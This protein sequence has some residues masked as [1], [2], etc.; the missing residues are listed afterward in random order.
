MQVLLRGCA[1]EEHSAVHPVSS[2]GVVIFGKCHHRQL[3]KLDPE[4]NGS[5]EIPLSVAST[6]DTPHGEIECWH[7]SRIEVSLLMSIPMRRGALLILMRCGILLL[8]Q[9]LTCSFL[10]AQATVSQHFATLE[11]SVLKVGSAQ[12]IRRADVELRAVTVQASSGG[13]T[14]TGDDTVL[15]VYRTTSDEAGGFV[16]EGVAPGTYLLSAQR[17]G[18]IPGVYGARAY[19]V[20][21]VQITVR[22]GD[23][24]RQLPVFLTPQAEIS[25]RVV[26]EDGEP[27]A[28]AFLAA[29][30]SGDSMPPRRPT[31]PSRPHAT[32]TTNDRGEYRLHGIPPGK[33]VLQVIPSLQ[34]RSVVVERDGRRLG[35]VPVYA[36]DAASID[37]AQVVQLAAGDEIRDVHVVLRKTD[38]CRI[39]GQVFDKA[40]R[41]LREYSIQL[42]SSET[43]SPFPLATKGGR[44]SSGH[45]VLDGIPSGSYWLLVRAELRGQEVGFLNQL[46]VNGGN[47][48]DTLRIVVGPLVVL[49]G[50]VSVD[51]HS[52]PPP[53]L[54]VTLLSD[55]PV[56]PFVGYS[57]ESG[58]FSVGGVFPGAYRVS[59][60]GLQGHFLED[61]HLGENSILGR[62]VQ[63]ADSTAEV[64]VRLSSGGGHLSG[65]VMRDRTPGVGSVCLIPTSEEMR[66][67]PLLQ[68]S[69][70]DQHGRFELN[71]IRP[72]TY[73]LF[74]TSTTRCD[75]YFPDDFLRGKTV[76]RVEVSNGIRGQVDLA[77]EE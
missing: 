30:A 28:G 31:R 55:L 6:R 25:G 58:A 12:P 56:R 18:F 36:P 26:D 13:T 40:G 66:F 48:L 29:F 23:E 73:Y 37:R 10:N 20:L 34:M 44:I 33:F 1:P 2:P 76:R 38:I 15:G 32:A 68:Q 39:S 72:G 54:A 71:H 22:P 69:L 47:S 49:R 3:V 41:A 16:F 52:A 45:F 46:E 63:V 14:A 62:T 8:L 35:Y 57:D 60:G 21:G 24:L 5:K 43:G 53:G 11:G 19:N 4:S 42:I 51:D 74:S 67:W 65:L 27:V 70:V 64:L 50:R 77:Y 7:D 17:P 75:S 9:T 61:M 59:L